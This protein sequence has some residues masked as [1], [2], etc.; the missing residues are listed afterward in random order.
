M[1]D[2][3][4]HNVANKRFD[5]HIHE[6][7]KQASIF[8]VTEIGYLVSV[9][10]AISVRHRA[11]HNVHHVNETVFGCRVHSFF[12]WGALVCCR[13]YTTTKL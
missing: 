1:L 10:C 7:N 4:T 2:M 13:A 12:F 3:G 6:N 9:F 8:Y 5:Y 11:L